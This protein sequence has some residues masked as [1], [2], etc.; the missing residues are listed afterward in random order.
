MK[1][2]TG[3]EKNIENE[4]ISK[5]DFGSNKVSHRVG[6]PTYSNKINEQS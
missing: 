2:E 4:I 5:G 6:S 3:L 1:S